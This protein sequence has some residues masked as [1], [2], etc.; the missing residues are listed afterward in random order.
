VPVNVHYRRFDRGLTVY[1][2]ELLED[3]GVRLRTRAV[4]PQEFR[5]GVSAGLWRLGLLPREQVLS[6]VR[7]TYFYAEPFD[8]LEFF[9]QHDQFA[10]YYSDITTPLVKI[11]GEYFIT[12]LLL[13]VWIT[14]GGAAHEL[15][16]D[17][18]EHA[19]HSGHLSAEL[20]AHARAAIERLRAEIAAGQFPQRYL[21]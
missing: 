20:Q 17:E 14:P 9:D 19:I 12:D 16:W 10:G 6:A 15:D 7:K 2:E 3:D 13:D 8:V 11:D 1:T 18:F 5:A 4:I 21:R